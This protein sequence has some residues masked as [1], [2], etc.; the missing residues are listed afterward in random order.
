M[1]LS[2]LRF[3]SDRGLHGSNED[4][5]GDSIAGPFQ[6]YQM[7]LSETGACVRVMIPVTSVCAF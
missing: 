7:L 5:S 1:L 6:D 2:F 4:L 3:G